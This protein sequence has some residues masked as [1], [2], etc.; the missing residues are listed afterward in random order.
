MDR[1]LGHS[2][3]PKYAAPR[4]RRESD[5]RDV[6]ATIRAHHLVALL[7]CLLAGSLGA[8]DAAPA[9]DAGAPPPA[10]T[11]PSPPPVPPLPSP[12]PGAPAA[13]GGATEPAPAAT[14]AARA[15]ATVVGRAGQESYYQYLMG[16][17]G[18][19]NGDLGKAV[20]HFEQAAVTD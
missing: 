13:P 11:A 17:L 20:D 14:G 12:A 3:L 16:K 19:F 10:E 5:A 4:G 6:M 7:F 9:P 2:A 18:R 15:E 1:R 8:A